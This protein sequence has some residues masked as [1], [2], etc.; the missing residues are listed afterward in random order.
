MLKTKIA[1]RQIKESPSRIW[2]D[3]LISWPR[4]WTDRFHCVLLL[5]PELIAAIKPH[6]TM[7]NLMID[8]P[9][10][11]RSIHTGMDLPRSAFESVTL[12]NNTT[13]CPHSDCPEDSHTRDKGDAY[14]EDED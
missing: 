8:C 13:D 11:G 9:E 6:R 14:F 7:A 10:T 1:R 12:Q 2:N 4:P 3:I 5:L